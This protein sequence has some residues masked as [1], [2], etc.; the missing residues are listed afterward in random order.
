LFR[1]A[2]DGITSFSVL[3]L[4][5]ITA[6]GL[7]VA[8]MCLCYAVYV[9]GEVMIT[10]ITTPGWSTL[11]VA[12]MFLGSIQLIAIGIVGEYVGRI[13]METKRRPLFVLQDKRGFD[14]E[15]EEH[16]QI[17][18]PSANRKKVV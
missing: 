12:I 15:A 4:R 2:V 13:F 7:S 18:V 9:L 3:P 6:C 11:I 17:N 14:A 1:L 5:W 8:A 10:G 16:T